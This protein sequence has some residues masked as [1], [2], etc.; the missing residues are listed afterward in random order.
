MSQLVVEQ[1]QSGFD[2]HASGRAITSGLWRQIGRGWA[3]MEL[4]ASLRRQR[5]QL[6]SLDEAALKDIGLS[7]ADAFRA[8]QRPFWDLPKDQR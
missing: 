5:R 7:G 4:W 1:R 6:A 3:L 8:A 2:R